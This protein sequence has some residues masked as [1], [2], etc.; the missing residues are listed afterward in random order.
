MPC[1]PEC[2]ADNQRRQGSGAP[3]AQERDHEVS[4]KRPAELVDLI[5]NGA[6]HHDG[7]SKNHRGDL[8][9]G[10]S[11]R[12]EAR[13]MADIIE[14]SPEYE[15]EGCCSR[16]TQAQVEQI[17][18]GYV[19]GSIRVF[20]R[21]IYLVPQSPA[22]VKL[23]MTMWEDA[24]TRIARS[25]LTTCPGD[26]HGTRQASSRR[27]GSA[28]R[29]GS[30]VASPGVARLIPTEVSNDLVTSNANIA[31]GSWPMVQCGRP[32]GR[33]SKS[34]E[35]EPTKAAEGEGP[36]PVVQWA[37]HARGATRMRRGRHSM[38]LVDHRSGGV[39]KSRVLRQDPV[40][41]K[42][43]FRRSVTVPCRRDKV[44]TE[45]LGKFFVGLFAE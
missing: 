10:P 24:P 41:I 5:A 42:E 17:R 39:K 3:Q 6:D 11:N 12:E 25:S 30:S 8:R 38:A 33:Y 21:G 22:W 23:S 43:R 7:K 13:L 29:P 18:D 31:A 36:G 4:R 16:G 26:L 19:A 34:G 40:Q 35:N 28:N 37:P 44:R 15:S 20:S 32:A 45:V 9:P 2:Q 1:Q 14:P 27:R